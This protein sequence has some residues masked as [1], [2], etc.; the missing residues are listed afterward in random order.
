MEG[1]LQTRG[2]N[3]LQHGEAVHAA[4]QHLYKDLQARQCAEP[5]LSTWFAQHQSRTWTPDRARTYHRY[6]DCGKHLVLT[7]DEHG[8]R[9]FLEH[10]RAS[11]LQYAALFPHDHDTQWLIAHDMDLHTRRGDELATL[12]SEP[13]APTLYL[14]AWA[15]IQAN[16]MMFGGFESE[17][18]KIKRKRLI[19]TGKRWLEYMPALTAAIDTIELV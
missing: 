4:Y 7:I 10:A 17:S 1:C 13:L 9:H 11:F 8:R 18:Y 15:E 5:V 19:Q 12:W 16:A 14:T 3:M 6:H 2:V